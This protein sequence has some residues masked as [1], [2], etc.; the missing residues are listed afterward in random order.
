MT[1]HNKDEAMQWFLSHSSGT[2]TCERADG[3]Q[4]EC[5]SYPEAE[6][7]FNGEED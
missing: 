6:R 4:K 3:T 5:N 2:V 1:V 7:F